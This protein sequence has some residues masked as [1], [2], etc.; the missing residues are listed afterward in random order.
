MTEMNIEHRNV[1]TILVQKMQRV[2]HGCRRADDFEPCIG[3]LIR[4]VHGKQR[5]ILDY[6]RAPAS[7]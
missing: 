7:A 5:L 3:E 2:R 1:A 6:Q 4:D